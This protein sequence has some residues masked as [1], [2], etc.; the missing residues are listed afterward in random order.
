MK[1]RL[2]IA[3]VVLIAIVLLV[4]SVLQRPRRARP[5]GYDSLWVAL[6]ISDESDW[7][8]D[9]QRR[10]VVM[11]IFL[12]AR[13]SLQHCNEELYRAPV[14]GA[15]TIELLMQQQPEGMQLLYARAEDLPQFPQ[16]GRCLEQALE[17]TE[18]SP[19][20]GISVGTRWRLSAK[21]FLHPE[22]ELP[23]IPWWHRLVPPSWRSGGDSAIHIG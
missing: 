22:D 12:E 8:L 14:S 21:I 19:M 16:L 18:P 2:S 5:E 15:V 4:L 23:P 13:E 6:P 10:E 11:A 7:A 3:V 9:A 20:P 17:R 1:K